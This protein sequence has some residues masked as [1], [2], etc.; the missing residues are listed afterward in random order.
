MWDHKGQGN[1]SGLEFISHAVRVSSCQM[2]GINWDRM[3]EMS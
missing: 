2:G 3:H 1:E